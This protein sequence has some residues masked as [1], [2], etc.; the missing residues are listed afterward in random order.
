[1]VLTADHGGKD[2]PERERLAGVS[3]AARADPALSASAMGK[4]ITEKLGLKGSGLFAYASVLDGRSFG[5]IYVDRNLPAADRARLFEAAITAYRA[6]PQ[7]EAVF[8][9]RQIAETPVPTTPPETWTLIQRVR[10]S[11][12]P[13]RSGEFY[14]VLKKNIT[15]VADTTHTAATHGSVWDYDRRVPIL[16]WRPDESGTTVEHTVDTVDI[17][18]TLAGIIGLPVQPGSIDGHC[19]SEVPGASCPAR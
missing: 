18:P 8:T 11:Y 4:T 19:L 14:V 9:A 6:H 2:I 3:D 5:D 17:M 15:P 7:V 13:G 10:A 12:Y 16:F 1:V